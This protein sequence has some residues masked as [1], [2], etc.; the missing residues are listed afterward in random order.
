MAARISP[1]TVNRELT[2]LSA[3][4]SWARKDLFIACD[5]PVKGIRRPPEP[6]AR[7][8]RLLPDEERRLI[9]ALKTSGEGTERARPRNAN[10]L[11]IVLIALETAMRRG[12]ILSLRWENVDLEARVA[13]LPITKNGYARDV[14]LSTRAVEILH[15]RKIA[16]HAADGR[17][18]LASEP[19]IKQ[20]FERAVKSAREAYVEEC[21]RLG[22]CQDPRIMSDLHF[23]DLRHEATS[24]LAEKLPNL[25]EL[26]SV[27]GHRDLRSLKRY[28]HPIASALALKLQ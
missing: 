1:A 24:R 5:N 10:L 2:T 21:V 14:P 23:H 12:E 26:A 22:R 17:I 16:S 6:K 27:T 3:A 25:I 18:F 13:H 8:R 20:A 19:A 28:Y 7:N 9:E 11:P 4:Y 15:A